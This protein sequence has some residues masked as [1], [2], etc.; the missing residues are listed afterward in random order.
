MHLSRSLRSSGAAR[1]Q[2]QMCSSL[3]TRNPRKIAPEPEGSGCPYAKDPGR[4]MVLGVRTPGPP[5]RRTLQASE[6]SKWCQDRTKTERT[7]TTS[8][9]TVY[10][11]K[12]STYHYGSVV[13][14]SKYSTDGFG[15]VSRQNDNHNNPGVWLTWFLFP[16]KSS[17]LQ[18][19]GK[20]S[21]SWHQ[22][23]ASR[24]QLSQ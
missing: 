13:D 5:R 1:N 6:G 11:P 3:K 9:H 14:V 17:T 15:R 8:A 10:I 24:P 2:A 20:S 7:I 19:A 4:A 23:L 21:R 22:P 16:L 12:H 18:T